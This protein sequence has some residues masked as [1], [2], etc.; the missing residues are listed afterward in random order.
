VFLE[1]LA[2]LALLKG[3][4]SL[5]DFAINNDKQDE[6]FLPWCVE[7]VSSRSEL[8]ELQSRSGDILERASNNASRVKAAGHPRCSS[9]GKIHTGR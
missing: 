3:A 9:C 8:D 4:N 7:G 5:F 2:V 1:S 6:D